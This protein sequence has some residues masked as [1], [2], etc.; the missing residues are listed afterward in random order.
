MH[1]YGNESGKFTRA[2]AAAQRQTE[3]QRLFFSCIRSKSNENWMTS[4]S[5]WNRC[6]ICCANIGWVEHRRWWHRSERLR[7]IDFLNA[8]SSWHRTHSS[9]WINWCNW[10]KSA[11]TRM[12]WDYTRKWCPGQISLKLRVLCPESKCCCRQPCNCK[13]IFDKMFTAWKV[14]W[15]GNEKEAIPK[16][17]CIQ[18]RKQQHENNKWKI[19]YFILISWTSHPNIV[20]LYLQLYLVACNALIK[21]TP[22]HVQNVLIFE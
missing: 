5:D 7:V 6:T 12:A 10:C 14:S 22:K 16:H 15:T 20:T 21:C 2:H 4:E 17:Y 13:S 3:F 18:T 11:T 1:Q 9:R 19:I 8:F